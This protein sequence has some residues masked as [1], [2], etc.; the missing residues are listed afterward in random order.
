MSRYWL[1]LLMLLVPVGVFGA[2]TDTVYGFGN[3]EGML[4]ND[5][6]VFDVGLVSPDCFSEVGGGSFCN[7]NIGVSLSVD[8]EYAGYVPTSND[9]VGRMSYSVGE[10]VFDDRVV[11]AYPYR[12]YSWLVND[13]YNNRVFINDYSVSPLLSGVGG[14]N[15]NELMSGILEAIN[16]WLLISTKITIIITIYRE[17]DLPRN[18]VRDLI[19]L[20]IN[21]IP[22]QIESPQHGYWP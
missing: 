11:Y 1:L 8:P 7:D 2:S 20:S 5:L 12:Y 9:V 17:S 15:S 10:N 13:D 21:N 16:E 14:F 6:L 19:N 4:H 3:Y 18:E 22:F